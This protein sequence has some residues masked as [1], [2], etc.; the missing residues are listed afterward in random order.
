MSFFCTLFFSREKPK[1]KKENRNKALKFAIPKYILENKEEKYSAKIWRKA[2]EEMA[3]KYMEKSEG[4]VKDIPELFREYIELVRRSEDMFPLSLFSC[5]MSDISKKSESQN[6]IIGINSHHFIVYDHLFEVVY[7]SRM[8]A[9]IIQ[10]RA[11]NTLKILL[12]SSKQILKCIFKEKKEV[13]LFI[14]LVSEFSK[15]EEMDT[16]LFKQ[17]EAL[18]KGENQK[19]AMA[20]ALRGSIAF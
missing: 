16:S 9:D 18:R 2:I 10:A 8:H 4:N 20:G 14:E 3:S 1:I 17:F 11:S 5:E 7:S 19:G 13:E 15:N 12:F 6:V